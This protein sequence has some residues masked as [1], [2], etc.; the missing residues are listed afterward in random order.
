MARRRRRIIAI[1]FTDMASYSMQMAKNEQFALE[2]LGL[3]NRILTPIIERNRGV[4]IKHIGDA[5]MGK[6]DD[7]QSA[8]RAG[9]QVQA[10]IHEFNIGRSDETKILMRIGIHVGEVVEMDEDIFGHAVNLA[11]RI[12]PLGSTGDV[13][14]SRQARDL[15]GPSPEFQYEFLQSAI[16]KNID[17]PIDLYRVLP[18]TRD[19]PRKLRLIVITGPSA[20]GK[21]VVAS[22]CREE[23]IARDIY[24]GYLKTYTTRRRYGTADT[25]SSSR[26]YEPSMANTH[27][28]SRDELVKHPDVFF[29]YEKYGFTYGFSQSHLKQRDDYATLLLCIFDRLERLGEF[30]RAVKRVSE[31]EVYAIYLNAPEEDLKRRQRKRRA[32]ESEEKKLRMEEIARDLARYR[33]GLGKCRSHIDLVVQN[34][35]KVPVNTAVQKAVDGILAQFVE[36]KVKL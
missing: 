6:F 3:H 19:T 15:V 30:R 22:L 17:I 8:F 5:I 16:V 25:D 12:D 7:C 32:M 23:L 14:A 18:G 29:P 26:S 36:K 2:L 9:L 4:I 10:A 28:K 31:R 1:M 21:D 24:C 35:N 13:I 27:M 34:G 20:V 33:V 11:S